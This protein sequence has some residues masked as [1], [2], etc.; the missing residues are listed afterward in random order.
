M[1]ASLGAAEGPP[2]AASA[3][4]VGSLGGGLELPLRG[5]S[6]PRIRQDSPRD[7]LWFLGCLALGAVGRPP[8]RALRR[9]GRHT[10]IGS[11]EEVEARSLLPGAR[12]VFSVA[13][14]PNREF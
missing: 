6:A 14:P 11:A 3:A 5:R 9:C 1:R 8:S 4:G 10:R 7:A 12:V 13:K 2:A